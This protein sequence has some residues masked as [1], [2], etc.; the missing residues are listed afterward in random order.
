[1]PRPHI[2][3]VQCQNIAW[4]DREDGAQVKLLNVG[5]S[6]GEETLLVRYPPGFRQ[7]GGFPLRRAKEYFVL[8]G[9]LCVGDRSC[10]YHNYGFIPRGRDPLAWHSEGGATLLVFRHGYADPNSAS[11]IAQEISLDAPAMPWDV[12]TYDP[13]LS[14]LRLA[15]KILRLGPNN[16]CRTFLLTGMPHGIPAVDVLP[17][18]YH[19]H[20]EEMFMVA[21]EMWAPEGRMRQGA[22]FYR[23]SGIVHGPHV[24]ESGFFQIMRSP[25]T[26]FIKTHWA[27]TPTALPIGAPFQPILPDGSPDEWRRTWDG[28]APF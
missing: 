13:K 28:A 7:A 8:Q 14:H 21:G 11:D 22:Y 26:N 19:D 5:E 6:T 15:R 20:A 23:P 25:G 9:D 10:G 4:R 1:M 3:F 16:S 12:S 27:E 24:S 18:E 17:A 2:E